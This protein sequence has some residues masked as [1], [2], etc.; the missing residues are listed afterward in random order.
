VA[1]TV[2]LQD[3]V[4]LNPKFRNRNSLLTVLRTVITNN[5]LLLRLQAD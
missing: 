5:G 1:H 4:N 3:V 2:V